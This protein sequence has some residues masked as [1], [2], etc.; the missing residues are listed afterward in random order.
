MMEPNGILVAI[1]SGHHQEAYRLIDAADPSSFCAAAGIYAHALPNDTKGVLTDT[2]LHRAARRGHVEMCKRMLSRLPPAAV[3]CKKANNGATPLHLASIEGHIEVVE[4]LILSQ[5]D[6]N[7]TMDGVYG[8]R[9]VDDKFGEWTPLYF[10]VRQCQPAVVG[11]LLA[12]RAAVDQAANGG[13][14]PL[15]LAAQDGHAELVQ[16]LLAAGASVDATDDD[17]ESPL[18]HA[19]GHVSTDVASTLIDHGATV[20]FASDDG[21]T[22][23]MRAAYHGHAPLVV[24]LVEA[25]ASLDTVNASGESALLFACQ[26]NHMD[27]VSTLL[28][29]GADVEVAT[30]E[31]LRPLHTA[32]FNGHLD[33]VQWVARYGADRSTRCDGRTAEEW[34]AVNAK[35]SVAR[36][37]RETAEWTTPLHYLQL[38]PPPS[39]VSLLRGG[40]D[41]HA[42]LR[43]DAPSP[44]SLARSLAHAKLAPAGS[45]ADLVLRAAEGWGKETH[46]LFPAE[47]R[48]RAWRLFCIGWQLS[49][50]PGFAGTE[51]A[52]MDIWIC[53]VMPAAITRTSC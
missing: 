8:A 46:H 49:R 41:L 2:P 6:V 18:I 15:M 40:A 19:A 35:A 45:P 53:H 11:A 24:T 4:T 50:L 23:L 44:L 38:L 33:V 42:R 16:Q 3:N 29:A 12:A 39:A 34:A 27:A 1:D 36:W 25:K 30:N 5:A 10:A 43:D 51:A 48:L 7:V 28:C 20:D 22:A 21:T 32:A 37:L 13:T 31:G 14:T 26:E 47:A 52:M 17:G 9:D